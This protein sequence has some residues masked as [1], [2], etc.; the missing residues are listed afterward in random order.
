MKLPRKHAA[1]VRDAIDHWKDDGVLADAQAAALAA[2]IEVQYFDW[3]R[4]A[5]YS[6]WIALFSIV[7]SVSAALSD[8]MLRD[9]LALFFQAPALVKCGTLALVAAGFYRWG[10]TGRQ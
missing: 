10:F 9:M 3:R 6:F 1:V 4:L 7:A 5:K 8:R 2:T